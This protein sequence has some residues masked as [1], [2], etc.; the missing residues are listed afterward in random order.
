MLKEAKTLDSV[1][2]LFVFPGLSITQK[3]L[4]SS[5]PNYRIPQ[6]FVDLSQSYKTL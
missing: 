4:T 1:H 5:F 6:H 3:C 2:E